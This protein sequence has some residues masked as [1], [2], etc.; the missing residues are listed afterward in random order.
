MLFADKSRTEGC[1]IFNVGTVVGGAGEESRD[2]LLSC[3]G[4]DEG[5]DDGDDGDD[6]SDVAE[7]TG[8]I[9]CSKEWFPSPETFTCC[10]GEGGEDGE[11]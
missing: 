3:L 4:N 5:V 2:G 1:E 10:V 8:G 6:G 11:D 7:S 9:E